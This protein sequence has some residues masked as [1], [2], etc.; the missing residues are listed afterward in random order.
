M[1]VTKEE[2][3]STRVIKFIHFVEVWNLVNVNKVEDSKVLD[4]VGDAVEDFILFHALLVPVTAEADD[5]EA[6]V[7]GHDG[8]VNVPASVEVWEHVR[9]DEFRPF[10]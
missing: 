4:L 9:H 5:D 1:L 3:D 7:F 6:V 10:V 2:H 8:L